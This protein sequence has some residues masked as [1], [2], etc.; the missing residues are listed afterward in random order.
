MVPSQSTLC[1]L[2]NEKKNN[3]PIPLP[4]VPIDRKPPAHNECQEFTLKTDPADANST[5]YKFHM[6]YLKGTEDTCSIIAWV[7]DINHVIARLGVNQPVPANTLYTQCMHGTALST[8]KTTV[9][10]LCNNARNTAFDAAP[11]DAAHEVIRNQNNAHYYSQA[12]LHDSLNHMITELMP[13]HILCHTKR[14]LHRR[15]R[16]PADMKI[17]MFHNHLSNMILNELPHLPPFGNNQMLTIDDKERD[18]INSC[19]FEQYCDVN[20]PSDGY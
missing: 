7:D 13:E 1:D 14:Y 9:R 18:A 20:Q 11:N 10:R 8:F 16:K 4:L 17:R 3:D 5:E 2:G 6:H 12:I 15:C 19:V